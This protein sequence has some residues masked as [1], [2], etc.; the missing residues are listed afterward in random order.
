MPGAIPRGNQLRVIDLATGREETLAPSPAC[1]F[2]D[3]AWGS[4][5]RTLYATCI[6]SPWRGELVRIDRRGALQLLLADPVASFDKPMVSAGGGEVGLEQDLDGERARKRRDRGGEVLE[7][8][9]AGR[10][11]EASVERL[12]RADP[13]QPER[14]DALAQV[15]HPDR[16]PAPASIDD[17]IWIEAALDLV[18]VQE[19]E[20]GQE[21]RRRPEHGRSIGPIR[22][23]SALFGR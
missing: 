11:R 6:G 23:A 16:V 7:R 20:G 8:V 17:A 18:S 4:D 1:R 14:T 10:A 13:I 12:H 15:A 3:A 5:G 19:L 22:A 2:Q 21:S 9:E